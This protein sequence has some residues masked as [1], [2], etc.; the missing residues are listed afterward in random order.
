MY[1]INPN[2]FVVPVDSDDLIKTLSN[3]PKF[4]KA[5]D[6]EVAIFCSA[7]IEVI[8]K[9][10]RT[11][12][13]KESPQ[14][15]FTEGVF[16]STNS[17]EPDGYGQSSRLLLESLRNSGVNVSTNY[18]NQNVSL[19]YSYPHALE[20]VKSPA[21]IIYTMFESTKI[22]ESWVKTL[23]FADEVFVPSKFCQKAFKSR[24][25]DTTVI[26]L[27]YDD[28]TFTYKKKEP[29][30]VFTFIHYNSFNTRKGWDIVFNAFTKEFGDDKNVK[31][32]LKT[33]KENLPF[34]ILKSQYPNIEV[35]KGAIEKNKLCELLW[36]SDCFVFPSRGE[37]FGLTPL[38]ALATG[39][40]VI[41]PNGSGMSEYFDPKYFYGI[42]VESMRPAL[43]QNFTSTDTG[44]MIE[45]S[46]DDLRKQMRYVYEHRTE[47]YEKAQNGAEWVR[48]A[49]PISKTGKAIADVL[50]KY[51]D[52]VYEP[53][54][55]A[56]VNLVTLLW[57]SNGMGRVGEEVLLSLDRMGV[58]V[59]ILPDYLEEKGLQD[60]TLE[61]LKLSDTYAK[62]E[63]TL[64]YAI[65]TILPRDAS[66]HNFLHID[67]DTT[68]APAKWVE[69][70]NKYITKV[71]PSSTFV[72]DVFTKS[73]IKKPM[74][75]IRHGVATDRF[76]F[77]KRKVTKD[78]TFLT[79]GDISTRKGTDVLMEAFSEAFPT[80]K[81][82]KLIIKSNKALDWGK[83]E[84]PKDKRIKVITERYEHEDFL[85]LYN[86]ADCYVAPS[87]AEGFCLPALEAMSTGLP[88]IIHNW[89]GLTSL[90]N[91]KYNYPIGSG[92]L[93]KAETWP[94]PEEYQDDGI[95]DWKNPNKDELVKK[96]RYVY[97]N[98]VEA[99]KLGLRASKWAK[100]E[101][102]WD[103]QVS[104]MWLDMMKSTVIPHEEAKKEERE[105]GEFYEKAKITKDWAQMS[106]NAHKELF[107]ILKGLYPNKIIEAGCGPATMSAF[108][109]LPKF[110]IG[111]I[112][113]NQHKF[114]EVVAV[115]NDVKVL[116]VARQNLTQFGEVKL[117]N[118]D[119][120]TC[121]EKADVVFAQ[122]MLEHLT[123]EQM[124]ALVK[125]QL[126]Q[127]PFVV[128][129]V[130]NFDYKKN[131]F[132]NERLLTD[133]QFYQI[134]EGFDLNI[135]R[136][137]LEEDKKKMSILVFR[138]IKD[139]PTTSV[140][141]PVFN[142]KEL[143]INAIEALRKNTKDYE[144]IVIDNNS[145]D[146]IEKWLDQQKDLRVV[147]LCQ[148]LGVPGAKNIGMA[149]ANGKYICFLDNDTIA[150]EGWL[151][152]L[153]N[154]FKDQTV[155]FVGTDGY[156][157][158]KETKNFLGQQFDHGQEVEWAAHS[159]FVF[160]RRLIKE[161]GFLIDRD[162]WCMEDVD[163]C[164]RIR[165]LGY[166]G[167]TPLNKTNMEHLGGTTAK[168]MPAKL[169][170]FNQYATWV[171]RDWSDFINTRGL[172]SKIDIGSGD[173]P[174]QGY[175]HVDVQDVP[176]VDIISLADNINLPDSS[177]SEIYSSH[178][179]EHFR[180]NEFD[181]VL[182]EWHRVLKDGGCLTIK[183]PNILTVC[184]KLINKEVDYHL[185]VAWI[186]GGQRTKWDYHYWSYCFES[187]K[188][189][190]EKNGFVGVEDLKD[191][192]DWLKVK[193]FCKKDEILPLKDKRVSTDPTQVLFKGNHHHVFGGGEN[194]TFGVIK[195]LSELYPRLEVDV[196]TTQVDVKKGFD[197][198]LEK[199]NEPTNRQN[200]VFVCISH[201]S[202][203]QPKG[204][205]NVAVVF[206]PQYDWKQEIKRYD[207]VVAI[208]KYSADAIKEKWGVDSVI[209]PPSLDISK[210]KVS[211]KKKQIISVGRFFWQANGNKKNQHI[212]IEAFSKMPKD[213]KLVLVGSIQDIPYYETLKRMAK[214]LNIEFVHDIS[215]DKLVDLYAESKLSWSA[216]GY[217]TETPSSQ[218]HFGMVAVE[219]LA[220][221]CRTL[222]YNG[223]GMAEIEGVETWNTIDELVKLSVED[224][225]CDTVTLRQGVKKYSNEVVKKQWKELISKL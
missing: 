24:G 99:N 73:G 7:Q 214:G 30:D 64:Y 36:S 85:K 11:Q 16:M 187:M 179:A 154:E 100:E 174:H 34:P 191:V 10:A 127:A 43:Y 181:T 220:S 217:G 63:T 216:T 147:H 204:K 203:P 202:L 188:E 161:V 78:M 93:M 192:D 53:K 17:D 172:G 82:V 150:G 162:L 153:L 157:I 75:T 83:I 46:E 114:K 87:R 195:M 101:W 168:K 92:E 12:Q 97:E 184:K 33:V 129:S 134:F 189:K 177:V 167:M 185:G 112:E 109:S 94:Y 125:N 86:D 108:L 115:D 156:L 27:G 104:K 218:E 135:Y 31:L 160:P 144:L 39:T 95:G 176:H 180:E 155:G 210:F 48:Q 165:N 193:S 221:G 57:A 171:W 91:E 103:T 98:R 137:W 52:K 212:L 15:Q 131:D 145:T 120:F 37:G 3:N 55:Q 211:E 197:I 219:A 96:L 22:P 178:L 111:G 223:G 200:D 45:P 74:T 71:Y 198:D 23:S 77:I 215:F 32:I 146:G 60:R 123:N 88:V 58:T 148:N 106:A 26:P 126:E 6:N 173:N 105:W 132:G 65:P 18:K 225:D 170:L 116:D 51:K 190:L 182:Q 224:K 80:E 1:F 118:D 13:E 136:Y 209:I 29:K 89:S 79:C 113:P 152:N 142:N 122:G 19:V 208:S 2:G 76:P 159:I 143:T 28:K 4:R 128:H 67:W 163:Q 54:K 25:V 124:V 68:K 183:C 166:K 119:A 81:D 138:N 14:E 40:P 158:N 164:C 70:I 107:W 196:D 117:L 47:A 121:S 90:V 69:N 59:K 42:K 130:P 151:D 8:A 205:K 56:D 133:E 110:K 49:Y 206:Y 207:Q 66:T 9:K 35:I 61:L 194:M 199:L 141:M 140:I 139:A 102:D 201:F 222:V 175:I 72:E 21:K 186:Y 38:E 149:I 5:T 84:E 62:A 44:E 41:V 213:W 169:A 20:K 50:A